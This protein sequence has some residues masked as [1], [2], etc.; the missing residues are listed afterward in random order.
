MNYA[1][2]GEKVKTKYS[3]YKDIDSDALGRKM[4][5]KYPEYKSQLSFTNPALDKVDSPS[6]FNEFLSANER[7]SAGVR[8]T[9]LRGNF[10]Q[11]FNDPQKVEK[12]QDT[13]P[14]Q[15]MNLLEKSKF[16][17]EHPNVEQA[18]FQT[19]GAPSK[20]AGIAAD[21]A[22]NPLE[23]AGGVA[24]NWLMPGVYNVQQKLGSAKDAFG[25]FLSEK[26]GIGA[27]YP[28]RL[29]DLESKVASINSNAAKEIASTKAQINF[30][31]GNLASSKSEAIKSFSSLTDEALKLNE[32]SKVTLESKMPDVA[33]KSGQKIK[34]RFISVIRKH[35]DMYNTKLNS[36]LGGKNGDVYISPNK[37]LSSIE[38]SLL[39][40]SV[41]ISIDDSGKLILESS[42][43]TAEKRLANIY[44]KLKDSS[45]VG[46][47]DLI[48]NKQMLGR[49]VSYGKTYGYDD[50]LIN[51][52][53]HRL[54]G[55]IEKELP[56][57][58]QLNSET[59]EFLSLKDE[60][61]SRLD[62]FKQG[63]N[64]PRTFVENL[65]KTGGSP[66]EK[67]FLDKLKSELPDFDRLTH[68][69]RA[70]GKGLD[71]YDKA[72]SMVKNKDPKLLEKVTKDFDSKIAELNSNLD[73]IQARI[74]N[75]AESDS[76]PLIAS[77]TK[78]KDKIARIKK[79]KDTLIAVG[80]T[81]GAIAGGYG[82]VRL[83]NYGYNAAFKD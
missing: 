24:M 71:E 30:N 28:G 81:G 27:N 56:G 52:V 66:E 3:Q 38:D 61:N 4:V 5:S 37:V 29:A 11:G 23:I 33:Y 46:V 53:V 22:T 42:A 76:K 8:N 50:D 6:L 51:D 72:I 32:A 17:R 47:R 31:L 9:F 18:A 19:I 70:I 45:S 82:L 78:I 74:S 43:S 2:L 83:L 20:L 62:L 69:P 48:R 10:S 79:A 57:M 39:S 58:K 65:S 7:V 64:K 75:K 59:S 68:A 1:E 13:Y 40:R 54:G 41:P 55:R 14:Q 77:I 35:S 34:D 21:I 67:I 44:N 12:F 16:M 80:S 60:A 63:S 73:I 25:K 36:L 26:T 49:T 15:V